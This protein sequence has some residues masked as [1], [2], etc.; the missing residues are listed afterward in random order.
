MSS[1]EQGFD[2]GACYC[3]GN[4]CDDETQECEHDSLSDL[5]EDERRVGRISTRSHQLFDSARSDRSVV[6]EFER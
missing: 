5:L 1:T 4:A 6:E 2:H 3:A